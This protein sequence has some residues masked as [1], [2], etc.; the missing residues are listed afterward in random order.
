MEPTTA[1]ELLENIGQWRIRPL[2][3]DYFNITISLKSCKITHI[4]R[5]KNLLAHSLLERLSL[6]DLPIVALSVSVKPLNVIS[7]WLL[8]QFP[9]L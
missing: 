5:M 2:L 4:P 6:A 9:F 3:A 8:K 7:K 1:W